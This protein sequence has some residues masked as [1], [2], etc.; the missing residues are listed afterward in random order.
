MESM[1]NATINASI[2]MLIVLG[3]TAKVTT[4][5]TTLVS[6]KMKLANA[7]TNAMERVSFPALTRALMTDP[8]S[9]RMTD[10]SNTAKATSRNVSLLKSI[11][12][13]A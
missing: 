4:R 2:G 13:M 12:L 9:T 10:P 6:F 3:R 1:I 8:S 7:I 5:A 11:M